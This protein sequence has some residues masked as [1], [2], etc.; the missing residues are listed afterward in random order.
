MKFKVKYPNG[1]NGQLNLVIKDKRSTIIMIL[2]IVLCILVLILIV[3]L[4]V[5]YSVYKKN[6]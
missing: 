6:L 2:T 3:L 5:N 1:E 4:F